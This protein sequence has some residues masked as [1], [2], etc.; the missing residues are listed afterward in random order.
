MVRGARVNARYRRNFSWMVKQMLGHEEE[1]IGG[2]KWSNWRKGREL[3]QQKESRRA[4]T[5][6]HGAKGGVLSGRCRP[7]NPGC[8]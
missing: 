2:E 1:E 7:G 6:I 5:A 4:A 3:R 8:P